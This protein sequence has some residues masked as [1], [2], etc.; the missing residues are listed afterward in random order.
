ME[1]FDNFDYQKYNE[2]EDEEDDLFLKAVIIRPS[3]KG[4]KRKQ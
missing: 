1:N 4:I 2:M 3:K